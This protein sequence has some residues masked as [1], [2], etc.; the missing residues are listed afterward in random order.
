MNQPSVCIKA[1]RGADQRAS[2]QRGLHHGA[3]RRE[4]NTHTQGWRAGGTSA[5]AVFISATEGQGHRG[6]FAY[7]CY[8][9]VNRIQTDAFISHY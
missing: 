6:N 2:L 9:N 8:K 7:F 3:L 5:G 4:G 1:N